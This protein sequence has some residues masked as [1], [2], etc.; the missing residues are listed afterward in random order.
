[1]P[2]RWWKSNIV[3]MLGGVVVALVLGEVGLRMVGISYPMFYQYDTQVGYSLRPGAEGLLNKE[4]G[5]YSKINS[6]GLRDREHAFKKSSNSFRIAV[7]GD[8]YAE[9]MQVS[10]EE[11]FGAVLER[12]LNGCPSLGGRQPEVMNFGVSGYGTAQEL[13]M[14]RSRV[15]P[16]DP[17][18]VILAFFSGNDVR[19]NSRALERDKFRP[20]FRTANGR[21]V[22][23]FTFRESF[24]FRLRQTDAARWVYRL[25][26]SSR[27]LQVFGEAMGRIN[28]LVAEVESRKFESRDAHAAD[29]AESDSVATEWDGYAEAGLDSQVYHEPRDPVWKEAW[30]ATEGLL[31]MMHDEVKERGTEFLVVTLSNSHQ[32]HPEPAARQV[33]AKHQGIQDLFYPDYRIRDFGTSK[34]I[35][36]LTLAPLFQNYAE[37][38]HVFLHGFE[39]SRIGTGHWNKA[40]HRLAGELIAQNVCANLP[41]PPVR[42]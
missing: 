31:V 23:D 32:V 6:A 4:G 26:S 5:A 18:M 41:T 29:H 27:I 13:L 40:G 2:K 3:L 1:M 7:L 34:D 10:M 12:E 33:F 24:G 28:A 8:S 42:S 22:S 19:N 11:A 37:Q 20:Y 21:L 25:R 9:A 16:Y 14:L 36:V 30:E 15:W 38:R 39:N 35:S 17:D